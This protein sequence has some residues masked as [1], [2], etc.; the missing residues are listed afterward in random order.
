LLGVIAAKEFPLCYEGFVKNILDNLNNTTDATMIDT[1]LRVMINILNECDDRCAMITGEILPVIMNVF[2]NSTLN[3]KNRE[4]CLKIIT[5]L[6]N[7]LSYA[8]GTDPEIISRNLDN[9]S[10]I[11][12]CIGLFI[13]ILVSNPKF[14]F[15][16]KKNTIKV[17]FN[18]LDT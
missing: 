6:L 10:R 15:D 16:I 9:N 13:S 18:N 12:E 8:D 5:Q 2:K 17:I 14:L 7:K 3:Q 1:Y 11:E 4:K